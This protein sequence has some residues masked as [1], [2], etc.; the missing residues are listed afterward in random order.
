[1]IAYLVLL[2]SLTA[3]DFLESIR[4][5]RSRDKLAAAMLFTLAAAIGVFAH[6]SAG[7]NSMVGHLMKWMG[8]LQ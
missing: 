1:M 8:D 3:L 4:H 6:L 7:A 5:L 2:T